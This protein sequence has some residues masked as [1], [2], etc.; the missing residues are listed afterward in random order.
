[1][2]PKYRKLQRALGA[3]FA[4]QLAQR[5]KVTPTLEKIRN[6]GQRGHDST[7]LGAQSAAHLVTPT[8]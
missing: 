6:E 7:V 8:R 5:R 2:A 1:M 3:Q 4:G